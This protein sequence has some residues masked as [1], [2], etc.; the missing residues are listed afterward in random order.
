MMLR[1]YFS[2][3]NNLNWSVKDGGYRY[4]EKMGDGCSTS[5]GNFESQRKDRRKDVNVWLVLR[6]E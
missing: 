5:W 4:G 2:E 3:R 1:E 6:V